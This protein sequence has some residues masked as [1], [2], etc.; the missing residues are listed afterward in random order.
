MP[1]YYYCNV[2]LQLLYMS[3]LI[4]I[5]SC[6][7]VILRYLIVTLRYQIVIINK[8]PYCNCKLPNRYFKS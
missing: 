3:K 1:S 7:I 6:Q 4:V 5:V 2:S 8:L